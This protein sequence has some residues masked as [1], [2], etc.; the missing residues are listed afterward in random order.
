M[1]AI[2]NAD[3][4]CDSCADKIRQSV[5]DERALAGL[6]PIDEQDEYS[7]DSDEFPKYMNDDEESDSPQHCASNEECLEAIVLPSGR[8]IGALLSAELTSD[9]V[10]YVEE[11]INEGGEVSEL[12]AEHFKSYFDNLHQCPHCKCHFTD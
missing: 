6:P 4:W 1:P 5:R 8:K 9:G 3:V 11:Y 2:Y 7:Y 12:W 10:K